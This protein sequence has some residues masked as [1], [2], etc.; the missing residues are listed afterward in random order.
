MSLWLRQEVQAVLRRGDGELNALPDTF[1]TQESAIEA[2]IH[3]GKQKIDL[4]F[5]RRSVVVN[6]CGVSCSSAQVLIINLL[7]V[8][9]IVGCVLPAIGFVHLYRLP[10]SS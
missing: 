3:A 6:G 7:L 4:G 2:A 8:L 9:G 5:E 1:L 10:L